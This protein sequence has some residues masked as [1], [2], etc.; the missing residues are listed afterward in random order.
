MFE[1]E[2]SFDKLT[3]LLIMDN[4][5]IRRW[6]KIYLEQRLEG[7]GRSLYNGSADS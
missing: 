4:A 1:K 5:P 3:D 6:F 2:Y 7:P